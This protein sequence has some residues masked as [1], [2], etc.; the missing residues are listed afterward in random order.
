LLSVIL[1]YAM[2]VK[3]D[4]DAA[5][6]DGV[7]GMAE[8]RDDLDEIERAAPRAADLTHQLLAF[9][10]REMINPEVISLN[11]VV[12]E[13]EQ[14]LRRTLGEHIRLRRVLSDDPWPIL[15]DARQMAQ[16]LINLSVNAR[17]AMP[18]GGALLIE[19]AN[20][21]VDESYAST[22][23]GLAPGRYVRLRVSDTGTGMDATTL[24]HAFEPFF[25]TKPK[26]AGTGL[27]LATMYGI[28]TQSGG[29]AQR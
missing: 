12:A 26:G 6:A 11:D 13:I 28:V 24:E 9:A 14:L 5:A 2:F 19:T 23:P 16:V 3:D 10:R 8:A 22:R 29:H 21:E 25:T 1:N 17:D 20:I 27:G 18:S 7:E 15:A 4:I